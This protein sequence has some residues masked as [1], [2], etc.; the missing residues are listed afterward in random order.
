MF[1]FNIVFAAQRFVGM[2]SGT[3]KSHVTMAA[4]YDMR[5]RRYYCN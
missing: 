2:V 1:F 5:S 4:F 3:K